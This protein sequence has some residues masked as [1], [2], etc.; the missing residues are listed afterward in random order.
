MKYQPYDY[1]LHATRHVV[2]HTHAALFMEMGLGKTVATLTAFDE[3]RKSG[4]VTT[5][6]IIAPKRVVESVWSQESA[7][8]DHL[9]HLRFSPV[10]G[11][12][13]KRKLALQAKADLYLINRENVDWL[14]AQ[15]GGKLPFDMWII[16]E[17]SS[18]KSPKSIRFKAL[19]MAQPSAKRV[20][21]LTGTPAPNNL[22]DIWPQIYLL[23]RGERLGKTIGEYRRH[24]FNP[25]QS[26]GF[27]V[28]NYNLKKD[29]NPIVG[30]DIYKQI[31]YDKISDV[32]ISMKTEDY[33]QL[34]P[35][36][37]RDIQ[38]AAPPA[39]IEL[40]NEFERAQVLALS[41]A[42]EISAVNAAALTN[43]LLQFANGAIYDETKAWH[44][45]HRLKLDALEDIIEDA[46]GSPI[47]IF[48]SFRHDLERMVKR[49]KVHELGGDKD[50]Q[51]WNRGDIP[52]LAAHPAG[53]GHGLNMQS[54]GSICVSFGLNWSLE[55]MQQAPKRLHRPGIVRP[56]I[57]NRLICPWTMDVDVAASLALKEKGQA[58][59]MDAV[60]ARVRKYAKMIA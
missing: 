20:V 15:Y 53:A 59:L 45:I 44:E 30:E 16:D 31:I 51:A 24:Y 4:T 18:F 19:R 29:K 33:Q 35:L 39:L 43:K 57:H 50:V 1:Q 8:W 12:E 21:L 47:L 49:F 48:Y 42:G 36:I 56:V 17:S 27:V 52:L 22:L 6:L 38:I 11:N 9:R 25:G 40:Y 55:L 23:D 5:A 46:Q 58:A 60:K 54:G 34:P 37:E 28:F 7:K 10:L 41:E 3:L 2:D 13:K 26:N 14:V 32:A